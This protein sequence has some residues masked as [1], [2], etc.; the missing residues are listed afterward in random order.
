MCEEVSANFKDSMHPDKPLLAGVSERFLVG[1]WGSGFLTIVSGRGTSLSKKKVIPGPATF[2]YNS[3][4]SFYAGSHN[5]VYK[6]SPD[7]TVEETIGI[8]GTA[9]SLFVHKGAMYVHAFGSETRYAK[10]RRNTVLKI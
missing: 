4:E 9:E 2:V 3:P 5:G 1:K 8:E 10:Y 6:V 7:G